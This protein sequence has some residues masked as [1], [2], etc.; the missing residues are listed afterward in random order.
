MLIKNEGVN[1]V[2]IK[3]EYDQAVGGTPA[4]CKKEKA[5][6]H[7]N[8]VVFKDLILLVGHKRKTW[9]VAFW[10]ITNCKTNEYTKGNCHLTRM[11]LIKK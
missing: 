7:L 2:P 9:N 11:H 1:K 8:E 10:L 3:E 6:Y 5:L 4:H